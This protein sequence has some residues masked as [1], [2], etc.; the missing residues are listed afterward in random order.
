MRNWP[1]ALV[2]HLRTPTPTPARLLKITLTTGGAF[3]LTTHDQ[4]IEFEGLRYSA[5]QGFDSSIIASDT[6]L[7]VDNAEATALLAATIDGI[8]ARTVARGEL[9]DAAWEMRVVNWADLSMGAGLLDAGDLG[10][11]KV[12]DGQIYV[13]ELL[14]YTMRLRQITGTLW[15]RRCRAEFGTPPN[16]QRGC[17]VNAEVLWRP[18]VVTG[19]DPEDPFRVFADSNLGGDFFPGR[20]RWTSGPNEGLRVH[21]LE[22]YS[23]ASGTVALFDALVFPV[24]AGHRFE[25]R[26]D[27]N[28]SPSQC[29][30]YGNFLD[31]KG[32]PFTPVGD[33]LET[34]VPSAQVFGG[35]SGSTI[36]D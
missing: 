22:A 12:V 31:Y 24:E 6:G 19:V 27:C 11:V 28:K 36:E 13:P 25:I 9:D 18:G 5:L 17:G 1:P 26:P 10:E 15:S 16:S 32:E 30:T 33:G 35:V 2:A 23:E 29:L 14:S 34:M 21:A 20:V 4:A 3:G 7:A 8:T